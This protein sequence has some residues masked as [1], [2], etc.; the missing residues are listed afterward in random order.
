MKTTARLHIT[1]TAPAAQRGKASPLPQSPS[2]RD[3]APRRPLKFGIWDLEFFWDLGFGIWNLRAKRALGFLRPTPLATLALLAA[4]FPATPAPAEPAPGARP[5]ILLLLSDDHSVPDLGCYGNTSLTT[6]NIDA[7]AAQSMRFTH[8]F[9]AAPQCVP[10]RASLLTGISPVAA[11]MTRFTSPLPPD[12]VTLPEL[13]KNEAGY[14]TG[15]CRRSH[16][17]DTFNIGPVTNAL[18]KKHDLLTFGRRLDFTNVDNRRQNTRAIVRE[19]LDKVPKGRP[20]FLWFNFNDPHQ[21]WNADP[22]RIDKSKIKLPAELP[23]LPAVRSDLARHYACIERMDEEFQWVLDILKQR[24]LDENTLVIFMGDNGYSM[25][26]GKGMLHDPGLRVPLIVRW[27][28][29]T[30]PNTVSDALLSGEDLAPT[31]LAAAGVP[32]PARMTGRSFAPLL[33][34]KPYS[35]NKYI[36]AT[37]GTHGKRPL[38]EAISA[39]TFDCSRAVRSARYKLIYNA[40]PHM[41]LQPPDAVVASEPCWREIIAAHKAGT[42]GEPYETLYFKQRPIMEFYDLQADPRELNNLSGNPEYAPI[43]TAHRHAL[44]EKMLLD[45][46]YLP[47]PEE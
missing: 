34:G 12:V 22:S 4:P 17:L 10:S 45:Y 26:R 33:Q 41:P 6:P 3:G 15:V 14:Y 43:E 42:L 1:T 8:M 2:P 37:R 31:L 39:V 13:L 27:P 9:T 20:W 11:R 47:L 35:P 19:F 29:R 32:V 7:F 24:G 21:P 44:I 23:D 38:T 36:F 5:N 18:L 16:H 25:P 46:D 28:G 40:T 30:R